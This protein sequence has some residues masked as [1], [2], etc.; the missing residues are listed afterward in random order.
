M[1][2]QHRRESQNIHVMDDYMQQFQSY[3]PWYESRRRHPLI[4]EITYRRIKRLL[5]ISLCLITLPFVLPILGLCCLAIKLDS[6]GPL[7][8]LQERTGK[9]GR[10]FKMYKLRTMI[11]NA[12]S[13][14]AEYMHLNELSYPDF[15]IREDPRITTVGSFL[16]KT[17]LDELPQIFNVLKGEMSW[18]GPRPTSFSAQTYS[19]WHTTRLDIVPGITGL[20]QILGRN[21]LDFDKRLRLDIAYLR[22]QCLWL[23]IRILI[24]TIGC[25]FNGKGAN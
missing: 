1:N 15:K 16:R 3:K 4:N 9:G 8:F 12:E 20:W 6:C 5:D 19:L 21:E 23:D 10:R 14:K 22:H 13:L 25:I 2:N 7:F 17:S 18:I 24:R 11:A